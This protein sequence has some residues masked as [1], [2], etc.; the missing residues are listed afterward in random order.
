MASANLEASPR[1]FEWSVIFPGMFLSLAITIV[2]VQFGSIIG[3]S[4]TSPLRGEGTM[5]MW[6]VVATG[7][8]LLWV[9]LLSSLAGGYL[10]GSLRTSNASLTAHD[11]EMRDGMTGLLVWSVSTVAVFIAVSIAAAFATYLSLHTNSYVPDGDLTRLEKNTAIIFAFAAGATS[12][13]SAAAAWWA[14]VKG[15]DHRDQNT[16]FSRYFSFR[17]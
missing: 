2:L 10:S 15:G 17:K 14:A 3:L 1:R 7:I 12:I 13:I 5:A 4:A 16:D 8:W 9:Q 6:G 11:N